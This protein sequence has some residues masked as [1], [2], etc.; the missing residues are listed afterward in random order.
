MVE[1]KMLKQNIQSKE[2]ITLYLESSRP[3]IILSNTICY[4]RNH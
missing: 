4:N 3:T 2:E 1:I